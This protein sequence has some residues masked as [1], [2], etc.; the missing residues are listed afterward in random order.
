LLRSRWLHD[1]RDSEASEGDY[2]RVSGR[3]AS[4]MANG[5]VWSRYSSGQTRR[6][7]AHDQHARGDQ[8]HSL[9]ATHRL[10]V[11]LASRDGFPPRSTV[12]NI[13]RNFQ[14]DGVWD[15]IW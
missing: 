5:G 15:A 6:A 3:Y 1:S 14:K 12:Y 9:S 13:F 2:E 7:S 8:R 4:D 11:A 10:P